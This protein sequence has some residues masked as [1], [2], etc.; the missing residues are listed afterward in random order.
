MLE[1]FLIQLIER[2]DTLIYFFLNTIICFESFHTI[3]YCSFLYKI[4]HVKKMCHVSVK[5]CFYRTCNNTEL[6]IIAKDE[7]LLK[8]CMI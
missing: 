3:M 5:M 8:R 1:K 2:L 7:F 4:G 6:L